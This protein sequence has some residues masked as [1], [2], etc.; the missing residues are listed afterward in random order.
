MSF[1]TARTVDVLGI[2]FGPAQ[3]A[4]AYALADEGLGGRA[5]FLEAQDGF[6]WH[7]GMLLPEATMQINFTKDLVTP[8]RPTHWASFLNYLHEQ[9][10][11]SSFTNLKTMFPTR[12]EFSDYLGWA[13][14]RVPCEVRYGRRVRSV[15]WDAGLGRFVVAA[16]EQLWHARHLVAGMGLR[17]RLPEGVQEGARI[18]HTEHLLPRLEAFG[19]REAHRFMVVGAGQSA[20]ETVRHLLHAFPRSEVLAVMQGY[21][22]AP[23]DDSPFVNRVFDP[24][25]VDEFYAASP[26]GRAHLLRAHR[27]TNYSVVDA[28]LIH[29]LARLEYEQRR[30]PEP[31]FLLRNLTSLVACAEREGGVE[32]ELRDL[33]DGARSRERV[34]ALVLATGYRPASPAALVER[35]ERIFA[36]LRDGVPEVDRM[37]RVRLREGVGGSMWMHGADEGVHGLSTTL[38]SNVAVRGGEIAGEIARALG[39][40]APAE[41][42]AGA[43]GAAG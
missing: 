28:E 21:G 33:R 3:L 35:P 18:W 19:A 31:R 6:R 37:Y 23:A 22:F 5:V 2:G 11:L 30:G 9:G 17:P 38:L 25:A 8:R 1:S 41:L 12:A 15:D 27:N 4:L 24:E 16:G 40:R 29:E 39:V 26:A 7:P 10:R 34:D 32:A 36:G 20:A 13:A 43:A 14:D 42:A